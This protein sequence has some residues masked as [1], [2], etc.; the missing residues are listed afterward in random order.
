MKGVLCSVLSCG[1]KVSCGKPSLLMFPV[2][3]PEILYNGRSVE[4]QL[5][6]AFVEKSEK[7]ECT[8]WAQRYSN[9]IIREECYTV[10]IIQNV[11]ELDII[12]R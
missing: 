11:Q 8:S 9:H 7:S 5:C 1:L 12:G 3:Y 6:S 2:L 10:E 4:S